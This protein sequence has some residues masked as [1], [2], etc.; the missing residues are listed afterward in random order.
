MCQFPKCHKLVALPNLVRS[1]IIGMIF[2]WRARVIL[3]LLSAVTATTNA[4]FSTATPGQAKETEAR[5]YWTDPATGLTWAAKDNGK[6][7]SWHKAT[8][9]C[10][11]LRLDGNSDWRLATIDELEE[12][13]N[14]RAY[15]TE[16]VGSSDILHWNGDL[17]VNGG[18]QLT[19]VAN[20]AA[21]PSLMLMGNPIRLT[22]GILTSEQAEEKRD[23][24]I[25]P[26]AIP[27]IHCVCGTQVLSDPHPRTLLCKVSLYPHRKMRNRPRKHNRRPIGPILFRD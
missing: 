26:R 6:R 22:T 20:G 7:V 14:L 16:H 21:V 13:V 2:R 11:N 4:Q 23:L 27:R 8:K 5:G 15:A 12:L 9:Y 19:G 24:R 17:Q 18:L 25:S 3:V 10:R 1:T